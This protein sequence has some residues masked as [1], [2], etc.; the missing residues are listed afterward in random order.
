MKLS[1]SK[2]AMCGRRLVIT[3]HNDYLY[4]SFA[5]HFTTFP[6]ILEFKL[7]LIKRTSY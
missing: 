2:K 7:L 5:R 6:Y 4:G 3:S 1:S